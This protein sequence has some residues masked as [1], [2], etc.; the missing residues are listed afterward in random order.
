M[1]EPSY[2]EVVKKNIENSDRT[3]LSA[4]VANGFIPSPVRSNLGI[5]DLIGNKDRVMTEDNFM[6]IH[7]RIFITKL[8]HRMGDIWYE[9]Y[10]KL[11]DST[12][13]KA[14]EYLK[15]A[16]LKVRLPAPICAALSEVHPHSKHLEWS[17]EEFTSTILSTLIQLGFHKFVELQASWLSDDDKKK[18]DEFY[19]Q[20]KTYNVSKKQQVCIAIMHRMM[21]GDDNG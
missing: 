6:E 14:S 17:E 13:P 4:I 7:M 18:F 11:K 3:I 19:D 5:E 12:D 16:F 10:D 9:A 2:K 21:E 15:G 1:G 8:L 20:L